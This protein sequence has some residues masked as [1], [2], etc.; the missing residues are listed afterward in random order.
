M[1][2]PSSFDK[3]EGMSLIRKLSVHLE[4]CGDWLKD[5]R[6][7]V[8]GSRLANSLFDLKKKRLP[9]SNFTPEYTRQLARTGKGS[10]QPSSPA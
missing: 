9:S 6:G 8:S 4:G 5:L 7:L 1:I 10:A 3:L 2:P